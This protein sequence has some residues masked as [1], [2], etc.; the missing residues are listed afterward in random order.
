MNYLPDV[1]VW[2]ALAFRQHGHH[3]AANRW[4]EATERDA[5]FCIC[6]M[7]QQGFLRLATHPKVLGSKAVTL[8]DAWHLY[9]SI[10]KDPRVFFGA[11]PRNI[12]TQ[13]REWTQTPQ[14][15]PHIWNDAYLAA[16]AQTADLEIVTFDHGFVQFPNLKV[17]FLK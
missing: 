11:E 16:F 1:N 2:L 8:P 7:T 17:T 4:F 3:A 14:F 12:E 6:R 10:L 5:L 15:S 13:W 9:D